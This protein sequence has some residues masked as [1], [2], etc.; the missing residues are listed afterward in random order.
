MPT[1]HPELAADTMRLAQLTAGVAT[2]PIIVHDARG[3]GF[4]RTVNRG[5]KQAQGDAMILNDDIEWFAY[6]WLDTLQ[7][8]L[9]SEGGYGLAGPSGKSSTKPMCYGWPGQS[10]LEVVDHLPFW[11]VLVKQAVVDRI[12]HLDE[13]FIHYGSDNYYCK[14]AAAAG[15]ASVWVR[16][17]FLKHTH[18]GSGLILKWKEHDDQIWAAKKRSL[19]SSTYTSPSVRA[20]R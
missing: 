10:G 9:Y 5:W 7:R 4:S 11:C 12:G 6:N 20:V 17:V 16:D 13:A 3:D 18:H 19:R 2:E 8:A 1:I 15:Y 14:Q